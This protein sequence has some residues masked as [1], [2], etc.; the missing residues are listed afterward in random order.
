MK[1][2]QIAH[3]ESQRISLV[4]KLNNLDPVKLEFSEGA[5]RWSILNVVEHLVL[6]EESS[7]NYALKKIQE[8][9]S[10]KGVS[11]KSRVYSLILST[12]LK[13]N[14]KFKA[15]EVA[16]PGVNPVTLDELNARW[17]AT[18]VQ[19]YNL[20]AESPDV[21]NKGILKHPFVGKMNF[22]Q[23][24]QFFEAHFEHHIVQINR[25]VEMQIMQKALVVE[26]A[27]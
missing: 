2:T 8:I 5:Q 13:F 3:L 6:S 22:N 26:V 27:K 23:M 25:L 19:L 11:F 21:L 12:V 1:D 15:P 16:K 10:L 14:L 18:R 4:N 7:V 9:E 17:E 20:S 24:L